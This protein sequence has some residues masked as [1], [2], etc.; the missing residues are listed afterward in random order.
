MLFWYFVFHISFFHPLIHHQCMMHSAHT[1][2]IFDH[3]VLVIFAPGHDVNVGSIV[4]HPQATLSLDESACCLASCSQDGA[5]KLW[6]LDRW[7]RWQIVM[8]QW[9]FLYSSSG[10]K[11]TM[12][13]GLNTDIL[14][15]CS[16]P[17]SFKRLNLGP[18]Q[19]WQITTDAVEN[20]DCCAWSLFTTNQTKFEFYIRTFSFH[21]QSY[22]LLYNACHTNHVIWLDAVRSP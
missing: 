6:S 2:I 5:V 3:V 1:F 12:N 15:K 4:F 17:H 10:I 7:I 18:R 19:N 16:I 13:V 8:L 11:A 20:W 21:W 22:F 14:Y 9:L